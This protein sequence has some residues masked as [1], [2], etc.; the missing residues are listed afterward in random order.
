MATPFNRDLVRG[1]LDLLV[2]SALAEGPKY[3][4]LIQ[5]RLREVSSKWRL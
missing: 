1:N 2:L 4:Y 3:G 5:K